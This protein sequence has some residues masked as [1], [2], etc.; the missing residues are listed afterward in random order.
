MKVK[1]LDLKYVGSSY[2]INGY[3]E[4]SINPNSVNSV[5]PPREKNVTYFIT[6]PVIHISFND[7]SSIEI[8]LKNMDDAKKEF[9]RI[10]S[11]LDKSQEAHQ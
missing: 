4:I 10:D 11:L 3:K 2:Q 7:K 8:S 5:Y 9:D 1:T 6:K